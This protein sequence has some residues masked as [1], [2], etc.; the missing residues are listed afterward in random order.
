M[1]NRPLLR[2][3]VNH[4]ALRPGTPVPGTHRSW[5]VSA[6]LTKCINSVERIMKI[7]N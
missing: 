2:T 1:I 6:F 5:K 3:V 7:Y 4:R